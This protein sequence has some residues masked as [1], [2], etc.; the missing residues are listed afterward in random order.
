MSGHGHREEEVRRMLDVPPAPVPADLL[1][2]ATGL[3]TR[4]LRR[5]RT[6]RRAGWFVLVAVAIAFAVWAAVVEPWTVPP[7]ETTPEIEGW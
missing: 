2:R 1:V 3:G 6:L 7:A 5:R 4:L